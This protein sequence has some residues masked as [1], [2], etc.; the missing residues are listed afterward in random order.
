ME[1]VWKTIKDHDGYECNVLGEIRNK[2][3]GH[4]L[5]PQ[6]DSCGGYSMVNVR[7]NDG[8]FHTVR[9]HV[10][11]AETF[12]GPRPIGYD[13]EHIDTNKKNNRL[14]NLEYCTRSEN[15]KRAYQKGL[16]SFVIPVRI[17]ETGEEFQTIEDCA[18]HING[19][20]ELIRQCLNPKYSRKK[21]KNYHFEALGD[22]NTGRTKTKVKIV[23]TGEVFDSLRE[24]ERAIDGA[25][26]NI[27][28]AIK[29]GCSYKDLH[30]E[31][32]DAEITRPSFLR[33]YQYDAVKRMK[34]GCILNGGVGSGKSR[35]S[36][37]Y[38]FTRYGGQKEPDYVPMTNPPDL[39]IITTAMK[40]DK[41]EWESELAPFLLSTTP[42]VNCHDNKVVVD[43]W[44]NIKKYSDVT[45]AFFIFDED[46]V[47]GSGAW[48][49]A[50]LKIAKNNEWIIL[51][52]SPGDQWIDY[53]PVFIA[54]NFY[55]NR[56]EFNR[57]HVIYK[58]FSKFPQIDRYI[59]TGKLIRLRNE[60]LVDMDFKRHTVEHHEDV[61]VDYDRITYKEVSKTRWDIFKD[62]PI[63]NAAGLCYVWRKIVNSDPSR[64]Q[65]LLGI[66][67]KHPKLIIF[68]SFDYE[69]DILLELFKSRNVKI[70]EWSGHFHEPLPQGD[71]WV[72]LV[73]YA[74]G[75]EGWNATT[76][77]TMVFFSQ[78]YS[79]KTLLQASGR[80][81]RLNT[82]F[83]DLYYYHLKTRS[84]IDI[85]ISRA[86]KEKKKFNETR[87]IGNL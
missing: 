68:Y 83:R 12:L 69:R 2:N 36:L 29:T 9:V 74:S 70:A 33:D 76:T 80:I 54:N 45:G 86:L 66:F 13:V 26:T 47:T 32:V 50:F 10:L 71:S 63:E 19:D 46:R 18:R 38:Y 43:S 87:F 31:E 49:K 25:H 44:N 41:F 77:D 22:N 59:N 56:T 20:A 78:T 16:N 42:E 60:I 5:K 65:A 72:Y 84:P 85:A 15:V 62:Q 67:E 7:H 1:E 48:V 37:Y 30:F 52:A 6:H 17:V 53:V 27:S 57:E 34:T 24:C 23:E 3:T 58:R 61:Y 75:A 51:S 82:P 14:D 64:T 73:N 40:R 39:Y 55:K 8:Y 11:I 81:N 28:K 4:V 79:Y 21:H 35:T